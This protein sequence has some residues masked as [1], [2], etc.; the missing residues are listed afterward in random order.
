MSGCAD[1]RIRINDREAYGRCES[2]SM[3]VFSD[4]RGRLLGAD[5]DAKPV[6]GERD[7]D[8]LILT[9]FPDETAVN[10]GAQ[11]DE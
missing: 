2:R 7:A 1:T 9:S 5:C 11:S 3:E 10:E 4:F 6:M 8:R